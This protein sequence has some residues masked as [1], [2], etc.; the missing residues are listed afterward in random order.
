MMKVRSLLVTGASGLL[1]ANLVLEAKRQSL[2]VTALYHRHAIDVTG[3]RCRGVA[4]IDCEAVNH[5]VEE[6][7]PDWIVHCAALTDV[8]Y[9][10]DHPDEAWAVNMEATLQLASAARETGAGMVYISTDA[11]FDGTRGNYGEEDAP[12]PL[13]VYARTKLAGE[14]AVRGALD[15]HLIIRTNIYGWN[16]QNKRSLAEWVLHRLETGATVPGFTDVAFNPLLVNDLADILMAMIASGLTGVFHV[17]AADVCSKYE[18]A[19]KIAKTFG[20]PAELVE[21]GC[22][23]NAALRA[24]RPAKA[25]LCSDRVVAALGRRMPTIEAGLSRFKTLRDLGLVVQLKTAMGGEQHA[26]NQN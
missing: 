4:L 18:F 21:P 15:R 8:D 22:V 14:E 17:A 13:N 3:I 7:R 24:R 20:L 1:G 26:T 9:C 5:A 6:T 2:E 23:T 19:L 11:V 25:T 10:E 16:A 12:N